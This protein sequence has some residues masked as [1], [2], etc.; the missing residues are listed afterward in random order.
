MRQESRLA[1]R[2]LLTT[3]RRPS[4]SQRT[5]LEAVETVE[6]NSVALYEQPYNRILAVGGGSFL[7]EFQEPGVNPKEPWQHHRVI[8]MV[9]CRHTNKT[10]SLN[11]WPRRVPPAYCLFMQKSRNKQRTITQAGDDSCV[12]IRS[13]YEWC[14]K[15]EA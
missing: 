8:I 5:G 11:L 14:T 7:P 6:L 9:T 2:P 4:L 15:A 13:R 10:G 1:R 3:G 12:G